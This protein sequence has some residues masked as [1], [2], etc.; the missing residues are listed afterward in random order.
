LRSSSFRCER[1]FFPCLFF[2]ISSP[3]PEY[4]SRRVSCLS[5]VRSFPSLPPPDT[6]FPQPSNNTCFFFF[7]SRRGKT[8]SVVTKK[9]LFAL[10]GLTGSFPSLSQEVW[11]VIGALFEFPPSPHAFF[12]PPGLSWSKFA[13]FSGI[14]SV[15]ESRFL[16]VTLVLPAFFFLSEKRTPATFPFWVVISFCVFWVRIRL[17]LCPPNYPRVVNRR[18]ENRGVFDLSPS[19]LRVLFVGF[20]TTSIPPFSLLSRNSFNI[21][22]FFLFPEVFWTSCLETSVGEFITTQ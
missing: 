3:P 4:H 6:P 14:L 20:F 12:F 9:K 17:L 16:Q 10:S 13:A 8:P 7:P 18:F 2:A 19:S 15:L 1:A 22:F 5:S 21:S 11:S